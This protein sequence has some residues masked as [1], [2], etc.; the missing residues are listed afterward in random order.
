MPTIEKSVRYRN[1]TIVLLEKFFSRKVMSLEGLGEE[2]KD[3]KT[4]DFGKVRMES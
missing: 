2:T 4:E 3:F 1:G